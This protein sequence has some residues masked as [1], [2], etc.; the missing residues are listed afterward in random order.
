MTLSDDKIQAEILG[1]FFKNLGKK[2]FFDSKEKAK[3]GLKK[4]GEP[5][6]IGPNVDSTFLS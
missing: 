4:I 6:K 2:G 5:L 1:D 3:N